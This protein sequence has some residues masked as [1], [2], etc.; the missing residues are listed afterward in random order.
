MEKMTKLLCMLALGAAMAMTSVSCER[1]ELSIETPEETGVS[2]VSVTAGAG[3]VQTKSAVVTDGS[4]RSL[5][6]TTGDRLYVR[7]LITGADPQKIVAGYLD[8]VGTPDVGATRADFSGT[9]SV[10]EFESAGTPDVYSPSTYDFADAANPLAE[11]SSILGWLVHNGAVGFTVD[12][13]QNGAYTNTIAATVDDLMTRSLP[14]YGYYDEGSF[15]L[16]MGDSPSTCTPIFNVNLSGLTADAEYTLVYRN[17]SDAFN[18]SETKTLG[19]ITA[20]GSGNAAFAC[21]VSGATTA[22]EYHGLLLTNTADGSD[23]KIASLATKALASKVYNVTRTAGS[24]ITLTAET[25]AVTLNNNDV[26]TGTGGT[27]TH[28]TIADGATVTLKDVTITSIPNDNNH[29]WAGITCAGDA[30]III[31]GTNT[32]KGGH[33]RYAGIYVPGDKDNPSNN[34]TLT[35]DGSGTLNAS[36]VNGAGIGGDASLTDAYQHGGNIIING[37]IINAT[38]Y[39]GAGIGTGQDCTCGNIT[40]NGGTV[41]TLSTSPWEGGAGIGTGYNNNLTSRC[42]DISITGGT[43]EATTLGGGAAIGTG[44]NDL[45]T[46]TCGNISITGGTVVAI[47]F[48]YWASGI[49]PGNCAAEDDHPAT[50]TCGTIT[51]GS[52]I[53]SV[54]AVTGGIA[55]GAISNEWYTCGTVTIDGHEMTTTEMTT[56]TASNTELPNLQWTESEVKDPDDDDVTMWTLTRRP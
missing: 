1:E 30:H 20:D 54:T 37:G 14:V 3:I 51:I 10:Y 21:Y 52:G 22:E 13:G 25:G 55:V 8:I 39:C 45:G 56:P 38:S 23:V 44:F 50:T 41:T 32:V 34:K 15:P 5:S 12:A 49:G 7:G 29:K 2:K 26:L 19:T 6:F 53:T 46:N 36:S 9:L 24:L 28:V 16:S 35:I 11:C 27:E 47:A 48:Y 17:G 4:T 43:V 40:I 33:N 42:G 18:I 31:E